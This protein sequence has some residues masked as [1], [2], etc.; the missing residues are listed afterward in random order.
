MCIFKNISVEYVWF[1][2]NIR[3]DCVSIYLISTFAAHWVVWWL[4]D[5][6]GDL[7]SWWKKGG[8]GEF[9]QVFLW[10][11]GRE[12]GVNCC[13]LW[14]RDGRFGSKVGQIGPKWDKSGAFSDQISVHL[15]HGTIWP[16]LEP[17]LPSLPLSHRWRHCVDDV[18]TL[19]HWRHCIV[20][21]IVG[22][23]TAKVLTSLL[24]VW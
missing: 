21:V 18:I 11:K 19:C 1:N 12:R 22:N 15:A 3:L 17:N 4:R 24:G 6:S 20:D 8:N 13:L 7:E 14:G 2:K 9:A 10:R 16:T 5:Q 23:V